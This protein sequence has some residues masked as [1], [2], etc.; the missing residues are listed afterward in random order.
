L[1][2]SGITLGV[3][4]MIGGWLWMSRSHKIDRIVDRLDQENRDRESYRQSN[5]EAQVKAAEARRAQWR[6]QVAAGK[7][8]ECKDCAGQRFKAMD[9]RPGEKSPLFHLRCRPCLGRQGFIEIKERRSP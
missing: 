3:I 7:A 2:I 9:P 1:W 5:H 4:L 8:V 6:E